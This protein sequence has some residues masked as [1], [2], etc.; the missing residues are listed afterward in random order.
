M[1]IEQLIATIVEMATGV[2]A[3]VSPVLSGPVLAV[4]VVFTGF[5]ALA[6]WSRRFD[7]RADEQAWAASAE[8]DL[9]P[10]G[11]DRFLHAAARPLANTPPVR[12]QLTSPFWRQTEIKLLA[13][14]LFSGSLE[15]FLAVQVLTAA[16][17]A[18]II[19]V[20][21]G[22]GLTGMQLAGAALLAVGFAGVP[23]AKVNELADKKATAVTRELPDFAELLI[24]ALQS[25]QTVEGAVK[26]A[27]EAMP[28]SVVGVEAAEMVNQ[29]AA[30]AL[31]EEEAYQLLGRRLG[32]DRAVMFF[33]D[34]GDAAVQGLSVT[35]GL[36]AQAQTMRNLYYQSLR[37]EAK[38]LPVK[39]VAI[40]GAFTMP[41]LFVI[42]LLPVLMSMSGVL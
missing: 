28:D 17:A 21:V 20:A 41:M 3:T 23:Y 34:L 12:S 5:A 6:V 37:A 14:G 39:L 38:K 19:V 9:F 40:L 4:A 13:S 2:W 33:R 11:T 31:P 36:K 1:D 26:L 22:A 15:V 10:L 18:G 7:D 30:R 24:M 32:S 8:A 27:A 25:G 16:V 35:D 42:T 29:L